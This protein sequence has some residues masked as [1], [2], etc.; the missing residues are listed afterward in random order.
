MANVD[1]FGVP[2]SYDLTPARPGPTLVFLHGWLLSR[3]Y[4]QP[5]IEQLQ[6]KYQCLAYDLRGFGQSNQLGAVNPEQSRGQ[7]NL[8]SDHSLSAIG[9]NSGPYGLATYAQDLLML[10]QTLGIQRP[11]L[12]GHSLGGSI[13]LWAAHLAPERIAGVIGVNAGGG[14]YWQQGFDRFRQAGQ[15]IVRFRPRWLAQVPLLELG[16]TRMMVQQTLSRGI[17]RQRLLDLLAADPVAAVG[18][19]LDSTTEAEVHCLPQIVAGLS[20]PLFMVAG[21]ADRVMEP[22]FVRYLASFHWLVQQGIDNVYELPDC[23]HMA[24]A[25]HPVTLAKTLEAWV[26]RFPR[27][28]AAEELGGVEAHDLG[29]AEARLG[30]EAER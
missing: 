2:H 3:H 30:A 8:S 23:G 10:L 7:V 5:V 29:E 27:G 21:G 6:P 16:F 14:I 24:M 11:W 4:W 19:L 20:Q 18:A 1:V 22:K 9:A 12:V 13:A 15:Q 26:Q 28:I 17:G 25:E